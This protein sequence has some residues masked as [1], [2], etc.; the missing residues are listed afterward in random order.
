MHNKKPSQLDRRGG[1][2]YA[3]IYLG[4]AQLSSVRQA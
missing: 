3:R 2:I 4:A 1:F